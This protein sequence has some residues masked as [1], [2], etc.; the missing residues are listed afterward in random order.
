MFKEITW[1]NLRSLD[2]LLPAASIRYRNLQPGCLAK[3]GYFML[4][5]K[6]PQMIYTT[7]VTLVSQFLYSWWLPKNTPKV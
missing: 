1:P 4:L 3:S 5:E 7:L 6:I 2:V